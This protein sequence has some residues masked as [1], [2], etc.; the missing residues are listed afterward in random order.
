M[1][2]WGD[3]SLDL[4]APF[5]EKVTYVSVVQEEGVLKEYNVT[6]SKSSLY[7]LSFV[8]LNTWVNTCR[9]KQTLAKL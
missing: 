2:G 6:T 4:I 8:L 5:L 9:T 1:W 3:F 7:F